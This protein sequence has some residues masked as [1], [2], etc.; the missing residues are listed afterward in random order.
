MAMAET[1]S[2]KPLNQGSFFAVLVMRKSEMMTD[3]LIA[4]LNEQDPA[5]PVK[6]THSKA[7][8]EWMVVRQATTGKWIRNRSRRRACKTRTDLIHVGD[9]LF[10]ASVD[11][12]SG[13]VDVG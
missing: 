2:N 9:I 8:M 1:E 4:I 12:G 7:V 5:V 3:G 6:G 10:L 11:Q 13:L